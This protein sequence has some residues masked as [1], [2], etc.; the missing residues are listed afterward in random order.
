MPTGPIRNVV[1]VIERAGGIVVPFDM[2]GVRIDGVSQ[3]PIDSELPPVFFYNQSSPGDRQRLTLSHEIGH[4]LMHHLPSPCE[5]DEADEFAAEF[6]MPA[7]EIRDELFD[8]T[9]RQAAAL[10]SRWHVSM[11]ALVY[12]AKELGAI[13]KDKYTRLFKELTAKGYRKSEP[14]PIP[15]ETPKLFQELLKVHQFSQRA[16]SD[17][18]REFLGEGRDEFVA[19]FVFT[20]EPRLSIF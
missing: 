19:K 8:L 20:D 6:L 13:S 2:K 3:W 5:E 7:D 16:T 4:M 17:E 11:Q 9:L 12:R 10:K 18:L 15:A 14:C 1:D